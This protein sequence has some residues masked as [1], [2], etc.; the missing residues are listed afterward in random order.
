MLCDAKIERFEVE[1]RIEMGDLLKRI[2]Q[3]PVQNSLDPSG[4]CSVFVSES[5]LC[6]SCEFERR[7]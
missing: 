3:R 5:S 2:L 4:D 1:R 6:D 7:R